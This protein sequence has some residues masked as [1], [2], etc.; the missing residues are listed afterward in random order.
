LDQQYWEVAAAILRRATGKKDINKGIEALQAAWKQGKGW[1]EPLFDDRGLRTIKADPKT[2]SDF[3]S[4]M[5]REG[6]RIAHVLTTSNTKYT[7]HE[8]QYNYGESAVDF[9]RSCMSGQGGSV[10]M[11]GIESITPDEIFNNSLITNKTYPGR[12]GKV[13]QQGTKLTTYLQLVMET[14][15]PWTE[16]NPL[17][18]YSNLDRSIVR[19]LVMDIYSQIV[20]YTKTSEDTVVLSI[21]P[22]DYLLISNHTTGYSSCQDIYTGGAKSGCISYLV[23]SQSAVS[24]AYRSSDT[25]QNLDIEVIWPRKTW[26]CMVYFDTIHKAALHIREYPGSSPHFASAARKLSSSVLIDHFKPEDKQWFFK[27][28]SSMTTVPGEERIKLFRMFLYSKNANWFY[29]DPIS[30]G[31]RLSD[32]KYPTGYDDLR[33]GN[34]EIPCVICGSPRSITKGD[35][36]CSYLVCMSCEG[37]AKCPACGSRRKIDEMKKSPRGKIYCQYCYS[38]H[39]HVCNMCG[40]EV[41]HRSSKRVYDG[42]VCNKCYENNYISCKDCGVSFKKD[43]AIVT[44]NGWIHCQ[45]CYRR[46]HYGEPYKKYSDVKPEEIKELQDKTKD[47]TMV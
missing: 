42:Y 33:V 17:N 18:K 35:S 6:I 23:D 5:W 8:L 26:R 2:G 21:N 1:M 19:D 30:F 37:I 7:L 22:I 46:F 45:S 4:N 28:N 43:T 12:P 41:S 11:L 3:L 44:E 31:V 24:Y 36:G 38:N 39:Y 27:S 10:N 34:T 15:F 20:A 47:F 13:I 16:G 40:K 25:I 14:D 32:G 29:G 9:I